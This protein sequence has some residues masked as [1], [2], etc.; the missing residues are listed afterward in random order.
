MKKLLSVLSIIVLSLAF[1]NEASSQQTLTIEP[2]EPT[3]G[4][5]YPFGGGF[6][7]PDDRWPPFMGFIYQNVPAFRLN[8]GDTLAFDLGQVNS[9]DVMLQIDMAATTTNGGIDPV[10]PFTTVV[11]NGQTP[12]NPNGDTII[13]NFE[14]M[15]TV[16]SPFSFPGGGLIIRFSNPSAQYVLNAGDACDQVLVNA[17]TS[18]SSENFV[19]RFFEDDDGLPPYDDD[20]DGDI[21]GFRIM[22]NDPIRNIPT[23]SEWGLVAMAGVLG[24]IGMLAVRRRRTAS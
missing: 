21:G 17:D 18:D 13:G 4:N 20:G 9:A 24:V 10:L 3:V 16:G 7:E 11:T 12:L 14:M 1:V 15:F 2:A 5:C 19:L 22:N 6:S 8:P 23:L